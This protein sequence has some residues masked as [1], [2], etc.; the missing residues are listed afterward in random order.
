MV[1]IER[2]HAIAQARRERSLGIA[3]GRGHLAQHRK[4][5]SLLLQERANNL[6]NHHS[7]N[8]LLPLCPASDD[9]VRIA[10]SS[11]RTVCVDSSPT[12]EPLQRLLRVGQT[13]QIFANALQEVESRGQFFY[14]DVA[15][16]GI[17]KIADQIRNPEATDRESK[18]LPVIRAIDQE[19]LRNGLKRL[20]ENTLDILTIQGWVLLR[21]ANE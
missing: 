6:G 7:G 17:H 3:N 9:G 4:I 16:L 5:V 2:C 14:F 19:Q 12:D 8:V 13:G 11:G 1:R 15:N 18:E 21:R 20:G 10:L